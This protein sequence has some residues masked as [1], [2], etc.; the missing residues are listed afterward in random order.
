MRASVA[1]LLDEATELDAALTSAADRELLAVLPGLEAVARRVDRLV[2]DVVAA[3]ERRGTFV[4]RGYRSSAG[5]L[6]DL[7][8]WDVPEA[9]RQ[10]TV[11]EQVCPRIGLD[12]SPLPPRLPA[13]A[14][15][16]ESGGVGLRH[17][18]AI[19]RVLG[20][21]AA[22]RLSPEV[23]AGAEQVLAEHA[24]RHTPAELRTF[25]TQLVATLDQDGPE[26]GDDPPPVNVSKPQP[27]HRPGS[28]RGRWSI[29]HSLG[30]MPE[31]RLGHWRHQRHQLGL[32]PADRRGGWMCDR[33]RNQSR[34][35]TILAAVEPASASE[36]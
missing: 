23:W 20:S 16:F 24:G 26:P 19:A 28:T 6:A 4:D 27:R 35:H 13:T 31:G 14:A 7:M 11:A 9:R 29:D 17:V 8:G 25:G 15:A 2:V 1:R 36:G 34:A 10:V 30:M 21:D 18:E 33:D 32:R 3:L 5:A 22:G 12:G